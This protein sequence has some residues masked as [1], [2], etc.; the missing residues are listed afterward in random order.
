[1]TIKS[2]TACGGI[3]TD[4]PSTAFAVPF[5]V[6]AA[7]AVLTVDSC[8]ASPVVERAVWLVLDQPP[9]FMVTATPPGNAG[10]PR[11]RLKT[12]PAAAPAAAANPDTPP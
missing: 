1:M 5:T 7:L 3:V 6:A 8:Q 2:P 4:V 11:L 10:R 9:F 12:L